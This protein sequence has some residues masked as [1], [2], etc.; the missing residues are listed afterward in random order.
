MMRMEQGLGGMGGLYDGLQKGC[1]KRSGWA[2]GL[3]MRLK[4]IGELWWKNI[5]EW[6]GLIMVA[7]GLMM[8]D[9]GWMNEMIDG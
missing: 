6:G 1:L 2:F 4:R 7:D 5:G 8:E 9:E 3:V